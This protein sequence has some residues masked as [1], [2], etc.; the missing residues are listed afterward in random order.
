[1]PQNKKNCDITI[2]HQSYQIMNE[3]FNLYTESHLHNI[4]VN[5]IAYNCAIRK[6][7]IDKSLISDNL[8]FSDGLLKYGLN[9][10]QQMNHYEDAYKND[11]FIPQHT[12][13]NLY[14]EY[15]FIY[16]SGG[17]EFDDEEWQLEKIKSYPKVYKPLTK[18]E[19]EFIYEI[20]LDGNNIVLPPIQN[21]DLKKI[22]FYDKSISKLSINLTRAFYYFDA[23]HF[24]SYTQSMI[25]RDGHDPK[26]IKDLIKTIEPYILDL[27]YFNL[28]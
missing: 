13:N 6:A 25:S 12:L 18:K 10:F 20:Q 1:M 26:T 23:I 7:C 2:Q 14:L 8:M 9:T 16:W 21:I 5:Q 17:D 11:I 3:I 19:L 27:E 15:P 22:P 24:Y 28:I 4:L